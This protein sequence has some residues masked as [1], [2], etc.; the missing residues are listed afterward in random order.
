MKKIALF[1][2]CIVSTFVLVGCGLTFPKITFQ[3]SKSTEKTTLTL[4]KT[5]STQEP[6]DTSKIVSEIYSQI[7]EKVY[8]EI[9]NQLLNDMREEIAND[10]TLVMDSIQSTIYNVV[11]NK[12]GFS[13]GVSTY[14]KT[15]SGETKGISTGSGVI[16]KKAGNVYYLFTNHHVIDEG[17]YFQ[18][19]FK[20]ETYLDLELIGSDEL[21]DIAVLKFTSTRTF[22]VATLG[23]SED[24]N[25]GE[26]V[27]AVGN[28]KG[29]NF[30]SSVTFGMISGL[31]RYIDVDSDDV[32]DMF[33][34]YIQHDAAINP[35]N[36]GGALVD[37][38]GKVVGVNV[39]KY[40]ATDIEGMGFSIPINLVKDV[41]YEIEETG[42]YNG[43]P[44]LGITFVDIS[45]TPAGTLAIPSS[46]KKGFYV[47]SVMAN[48]SCDG[49][50]LP[51][52][53]IIKIDDYT[54]ENTNSFISFFSKYRTGNTIVMTVLRN[55]AEIQFDVLLKKSPK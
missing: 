47:Q 20:D 4:A 46:V 30:F 3:T 16:Y 10:E 51:G 48:S 55:G 36:S 42:S 39:I 24:L 41:I 22:D 45:T 26:F 38:D 12:L 5:S 40:A 33:V 52:D 29:T 13:V 35:G 2:L 32:R 27:L 6:I 34:P 1:L 17:N 9:Y 37:L 31:K 54:I 11:N 50:V 15:E 7:Y 23:D 8:N 28:P 14:T 49:K 19:N 43:K 21:V 53:I 25:I 44:T 18:V